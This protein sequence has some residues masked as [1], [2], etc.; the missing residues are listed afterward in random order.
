MIIFYFQTSYLEDNELVHEK[1]LEA[2]DSN[3]AVETNETSVEVAGCQVNDLGLLRQLG[4][5][6]PKSE[7]GE[8]DAG[9]PGHNKQQVAQLEDLP[10]HASLF[11]VGEKTAPMVHRLSQVMNEEENDAESV[12]AHVVGGHD[13][14]QVEAGVLDLGRHV[15]LLG[16]LEIELGEDVEPVGDLDN[17][18]ELEH[19]CHIIVRISLPQGGQ[20]DHVLAVDDVA[21][22][23]EGDQVEA[24]QL[25]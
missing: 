1:S 18:E 5:A 16:L 17:E 25:A 22:P 19:E 7:N 10:G 2:A 11:H 20:V 3:Q 21:G 8:D 4:Q 23:E 6:E 15:L 9:E 13:K 24:E 14:G 12:E